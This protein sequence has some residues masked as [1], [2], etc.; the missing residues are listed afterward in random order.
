MVIHRRNKEPIKENE[1]DDG[2]GAYRV[3]QKE[4][5]FEE[6]R[7]DSFEKQKLK[8]SFQS[9]DNSD[10]YNMIFWIAVGLS[11]LVGLAC[12]ALVTYWCT[13]YGGFAWNSN[14]KLQFFVHP[15]LMVLGL[16]FFY[17]DAILVYRVLHFLPKWILKWI[18]ALLH[19][20]AAILASV[21]LIAVFENHRRTNKP[22]LYSL[23]SWV[24]ITTFGFF[25]LQ[26]VGSFMTFLFPG[27]PSSVRAKVM[28]FHRFFGVG[29]LILAVATALMGLTER[30]FW[31]DDYSDLPVKSVIGNCL[32]LSLI[33]FAFIVIFVSTHGMYKRRPLP[34]DVPAPVN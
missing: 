20:T 15:L 25:C 23:H 11:Q 33:T 27:L 22:D 4:S 7:T 28:P 8:S 29:I 16:I 32:G 17:G 21:G 13:L 12:I 5:S 19:L 9:Y 18:H 31:D 10:G 14:P 34:S 26:F 1:N 6:C 24:G 2:K 3:R 30:L